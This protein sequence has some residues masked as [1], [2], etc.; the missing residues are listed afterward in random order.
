MCTVVHRFSHTH[1]H[2]SRVLVVYLEACLCWGDV[3][4]P[5]RFPQ[6]ARTQ[7]RPTAFTLHTWTGIQ[8]AYGDCGYL[9]SLSSPPS[10]S[11]TSIHMG[12]PSFLSLTPPFRPL[13]LPTLSISPSYPSLLPSLPSLALPLFP[14]LPYRFVTTN[15]STFAAKIV[16]RFFFSKK[17]KKSARSR[18][19]H[20][21]A[22]PR[23]R[24]KRASVWQSVWEEWEGL[25][26]AKFHLL[27]PEKR[28]E[29]G[30][31][32]SKKSCA[33]TVARVEK[34]VFFWCQFDYMVWYHNM[35]G[36]VCVLISY[37]FEF[38]NSVHVEKLVLITT[39][40]VDYKW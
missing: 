16:G 36:C 5:W 25:A 26:L 31:E 19:K 13:D 12:S 3:S 18:C 38:T 32:K 11:V 7:R 21:A 29:G 8:S 6:P 34:L 9:A 20:A 33:S 22:F 17:K 14:P 28:Q 4:F 1:A 23:A 27:F 37:W 2:K 10:L 15:L 35:C 40:H 30:T 39:I 24:S